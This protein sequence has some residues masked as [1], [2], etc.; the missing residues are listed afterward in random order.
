[1]E[2]IPLGTPSAIKIVGTN[3]KPNFLGGTSHGNSNDFNF[4]SVFIDSVFNGMDHGHVF[5]WG[6]TDF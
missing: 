5:Y 1:L 6:L 3:L 2:K 4:D